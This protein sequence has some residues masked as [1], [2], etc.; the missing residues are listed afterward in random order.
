M[1]PVRAGAP[2]ASRGRIRALIISQ[3]VSRCGAPRRAPD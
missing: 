1:T 3:R 2:S